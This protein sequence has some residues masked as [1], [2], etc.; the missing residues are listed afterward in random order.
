[1]ELE[2]NNLDK[3]LNTLGDRLIDIY[4]KNL[5]QTDTNASGALG[6]T[7]NYI[8]EKDDLTY[9]VDINIEDY[10]KYIEEGRRP[11]KFPPV[12]SIRNWVRIKPVIPR[13]FS[14]KLPTEN[15]LVYLIGKK[16][17]EEGTEGKHL[18]QLSL[19]ELEMNWMQLIDAAIQ[20]DLENQVDI[21]FK[22]F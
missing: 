5:A 17:Q 7:I 19:E 2:F 10:W 13:P 21:Q 12:E 22:N 3:L 8:V 9:S 20:K 6:N 11:G 1:M 14:G 15:Q 16:I 4:R 18:M